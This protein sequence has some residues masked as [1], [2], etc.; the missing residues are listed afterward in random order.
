V[1]KFSYSITATNSNGEPVSWS[2]SR[3][4]FHTDGQSYEMAKIPKFTEGYAV[5]KFR[6]VDV[7]GNAGSDSSGDHVDMDLP[8]IRLAEVYLNYAEAVARSGGNSATALGLINQ[9]RTRAGAPEATLAEF[10]TQF[11]MDERSRELY[12]EGLRRTDLIRDGKFVSG[13][14]LWP[15]K[16]G[17]AQGAASD[18]YRKIFPIPEDVLLVNTN[19]QQNPNY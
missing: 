5:T 13:S 18:D 16:S 12:W 10:N 15:F 6:N 9:L 2:D 19:L 8:L 1:E 4:M 17:V 14:Y 11:V 7:N 3:A